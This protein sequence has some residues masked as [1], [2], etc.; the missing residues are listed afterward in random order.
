MRRRA[1]CS[2][3]C[4][5]SFVVKPVPV[6][7]ERAWKRAAS[8]DMPVSTSDTAV[9]LTMSSE[10]ASMRTSTTIAPMRAT[11]RKGCTRALGLVRPRSRP[12]GRITAT[13]AVGVGDGPST[14]D[15]T[16]TSPRLTCAAPCVMA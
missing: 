11:E 9:T 4:S 6:H 5:D 15:V 16:S 12:S 10:S 7:A 14:S 13:R 2:R 3:T 8:V 1:G